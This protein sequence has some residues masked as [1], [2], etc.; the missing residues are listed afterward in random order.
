MFINNHDDRLD[1]CLVNFFKCIPPLLVGIPDLSDHLRVEKLEPVGSCTGSQQQRSLRTRPS[2]AAQC[3]GH[4]QGAVWR[5][6]AL[7]V[8]NSRQHQF[9]LCS[10]VSWASNKHPFLNAEVLLGTW[11][12]FSRETRAEFHSLSCSLVLGTT[13]MGSI[14]SPTPPA[15]AKSL[16]DVFLDEEPAPFNPQ[17]VP[18]P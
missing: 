9:Y 2:P 18:D 3:P 12:P 13:S 6:V 15:L 7:R 16:K 8:L 1:M 14:L 10:V 17:P 5:D 4:R 11:S